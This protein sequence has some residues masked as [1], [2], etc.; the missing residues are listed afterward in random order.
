MKDIHPKSPRPSQGQ[1]DPS[2]EI[3]YAPKTYTAREQFATALKVLAV[4]GAI[5]LLI[6]FMDAMTS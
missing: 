4:S 6:W 3:D 2:T 1:R 5:L